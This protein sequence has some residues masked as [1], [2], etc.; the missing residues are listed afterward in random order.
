[1]GGTIESDTT[2]PRHSSTLTARNQ[3]RPGSPNDMIDL[4]SQDRVNYGLENIKTTRLGGTEEPYIQRNSD[5]N[6]KYR[7]T[8]STPSIDDRYQTVNPLLPSSP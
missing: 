1:M 8:N 7:T 5:T 6:I 2:S 3:K 4:S